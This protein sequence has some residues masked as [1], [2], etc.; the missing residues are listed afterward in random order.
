MKIKTRYQCQACA[1]TSPKWLGRCPNCGGWNTY[2]EEVVRPEAAEPTLKSGSLAAL[3]AEFQADA[4]ALEGLERAD[5]TR[6]GLP[7][8]DGW[9]P[10]DEEE[11]DGEGEAPKKAAQAAPRHRTGIGELDRVL[12]GG[13]VRDSFVLLG[14]DPGIGKSTLLLQM[15]RG[16]SATQKI[17][18]VSG[19]ESVEQIRS[20]AKRLG[21]VGAGNVFL[22]AE[23]QLERVFAMVK[24][25]KPRVLVV[26][27]LQTF[28][29]GY[30]ESAPGSVSQVREVASRLMALAKSARMAVLL[31]GHVTKEGAIAGPKL[32]EHLVD[33]V[34]YFEGEGGHTHR[35]LRAVKNRFGSSR[36]L[37]VFE[38]GPEGLIEVTNPSQLFLSDRGR[39]VPGTSVAAILEGTRCLLVEVQALV[40]KSALAMPRRTS[41]GLDQQRLSLL[42]AVLERHMDL[43]LASR[44]LFFNVAGGLRLPEPAADLAA[45]A[46]IW[47]SCA[48]HALPLDWAFVGE[49]GLTGEVR[50]V[51]LPEAR[52]DEAAKLGF[53]V[54]VVPAAGAQRIQAPAGVRV[55]PL[56]RIEELPKVL[57]LKAPSPDRRPA[58]SAPRAEETRPETPQ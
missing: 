39:A 35:L 7:A 49:V 28:V 22:A 6:G 40:A 41:V 57:G 55:I 5:L 54:V 42:A 32:I 47:S 26:D 1:A 29:S 24:D 15:T 45:V 21:V 23:T 58:R 38:M 50:R 14:G 34:L 46:A 53:K 51:S 33:T 36:E 56:S 44:D 43:A 12:G 17:L 31:V 13:L 9:V 30:L 11:G 19:E 25:L 20:R 48:D 3:R 10:L 27:S 18:Y 4:D 52:V 8:G 37:G 2:V 16:L